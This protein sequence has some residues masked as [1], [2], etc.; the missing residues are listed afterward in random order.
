MEDENQT[1]AVVRRLGGGGA[2]ARKLGLTRQAVNLWVSR[3]RFHD[4]HVERILSLCIA[5]NLPT[6]HPQ[7]RKAKAQR[8]RHAY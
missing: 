6:D 1:A 5:D 2:L 8:P 4:A 7:L 3:D